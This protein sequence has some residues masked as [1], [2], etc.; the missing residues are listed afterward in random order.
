MVVFAIPVVIFTIPVAF[1]H[2][3][4][5]TIVIVVRMIP[6]RSFVGRTFPMP[7]HPSVA[8]PLRGPIPLDPDVAWAWNRRAPLVTQRR[9]RASDIHGN[10]CRSRD[11]ETNC[12]QY[13]AYPIQFHFGFSRMLG[14]RLRNPPGK[15]PPPALP[16]A[17]S[18]YQLVPPPPSPL[19]SWNHRVSGN[20]LL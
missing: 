18:V 15:L 19:V 13:S 4:A 7:F 14:F 20:F 2:P 1:M 12:E 9:W 16:S 6:I 5:F 10:L 17:T 11:G 3:P 8:M